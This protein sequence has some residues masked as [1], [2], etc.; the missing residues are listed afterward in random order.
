MTSTRPPD[1]AATRRLLYVAPDYGRLSET[2][3]NGLIADLAGRG[4]EVTVVCSAAAP[5]ADPPPGVTLRQVPFAL[6][7]GPVDR[8]LGK[9]ERTAPGRG[10]WPRRRRSAAR[11]LAP[12]VAEARPDAA[13]IDYGSAAALAAG[14]LAAA[15]VPFA[16]HFHGADV[17]TAL[18]DDG[19]RAALPDLFGTAGALVVASHHV[20]RLLILEGAAPEKCRLVRLE[21]G[22]DGVEP[23][24]WERRR[25]EPPSVAF[26]GRLTAKKHPVALVEA[27]AI[28]RRTVPDAVLTII[29][30]GP[31]RPRVADRIRRLGLDDAV[32]LRPAVP[33]AEGLAEVARHWVFAQHS[34]TPFSGDQE[35]FALSPAEAALLELP[36][37][38]TWHNGIPEHVADGETGCLVREHDFE[39]MGERLAELLSDPDRC[40]RLG[41][42][43]RERVAALCP[44]GER[45]AAISDLLAELAARSPR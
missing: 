25:T 18:A 32:R 26:F 39:A 15:G 27:F 14:P 35:G 21:V 5:G 44:P 24:P 2:F 16:V 29:G 28:A 3:V 40:E 10:D 11:A 45:G 1:P 36:V 4:W 43:G 7:T 31:E 13:F 38:S 41:K 9:W 17:T 22:T 23:V 42:A 37:V 8:L 30:D 20:R 34:V 19:Y 33:R 6:L 12:V